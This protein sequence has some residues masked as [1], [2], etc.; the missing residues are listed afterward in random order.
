MLA[1]V[2]SHVLRLDAPR[3]AASLSG[4]LDERD[5]N[6]CAAEFDG[7]GQSRPA[8]T[9]DDDVHKLKVSK[10][11]ARKISCIHCYNHVLL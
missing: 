4:R 2:E 6:V 8:R 1:V 11:R 10:E 3:P 9:D 5:P 7:G